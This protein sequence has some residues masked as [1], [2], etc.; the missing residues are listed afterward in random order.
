M[1]KIFTVFITVSAIYTTSVYPDALKDSLVKMMNAEETTSGMVDLSRLDMNTAPKME[2]P[3]SRPS[4]AVVATVNGENIIKRDA[5]QYIAQRTKGQVTDFDL[6]PK[7]QQSMLVKELSIPRLAQ[8]SAKEELSQQ[9]K[10]AVFTRLWMQKKALENPVSDEHLRGVYDN[11]KKQAIENKSNKPIPEFNSIK[12]N[13][14][15]RIGEKIIVDKLMEDANITVI[16]AN[17]I[18]GSIN[19]LYVSIDDANNALNS[20]SKGK[21]TWRSIPASDKERVLT[22]I[23]PSK[24]IE[25]SL[26]K[27]LSTEEKDTGLANFWMQDKMMKTNVSDEELQTAYSRIEKEFKKSK[28]KQKLPEFEELKRSLHMQVAKE[29]VV[30][31]LM[32]TAKIKLK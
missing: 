28:S 15:S 6:L 19:G 32:K 30:S 8:L 10:T 29:K 17:M 24:L 31:N 23:A 22:M 20:I 7:E 26:D 25:V 1:N 3:K 11:L 16:D 12:N 4:A 14:K 27:D 9:E 21:S 2:K 18:A 5:D 13:M